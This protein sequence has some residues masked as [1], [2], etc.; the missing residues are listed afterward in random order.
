MTPILTLPAVVQLAGP[1][2]VVVTGPRLLKVY[3]SLI[4]ML[5]IVA[6]VIKENVLDRKGRTEVKKKET[7][8]NWGSS[9]TIRGSAPLARAS[10]GLGSRRV[11]IIPQRLARAKSLKTSR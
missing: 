9:C 10:V 6:R 3:P 8:T 2:K 1:L 5:G 11:G 4:V 7:K